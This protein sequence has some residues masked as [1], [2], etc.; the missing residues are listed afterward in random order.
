MLAPRPRRRRSKGIVPRHG[1]NDK[2]Q[3]QHGESNSQQPFAKA[4]FLNS[5]ARPVRIAH[6]DAA[7]ALQVNVFKG[8]WPK[9]C[10]FLFGF[11]LGL[12]NLLGDLFSSSLY[13]GSTHILA[14]SGGAAP[15][16][17]RSIPP[18]LY[19]GHAGIKM[20]SQSIF[21]LPPG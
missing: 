16:E 17:G 10:P 5:G 11:E 15:L 4:S 6:L 12:P 20:P 1:Q 8:S 9:D 2:D 21:C 13:I 7:C 18:L 14:G 19:H 3:C